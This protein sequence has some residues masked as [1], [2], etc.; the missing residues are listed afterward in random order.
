MV[1]AQ[2]YEISDVDFVYGFKDGVGGVHDSRTMMLAE[3]Q[4]LLEVC[5]QN[6]TPDQ[7]RTAVVEDNA[8]LKGSLEARRGAFRRLRELYGLNPE[9]LLF[10]ALRDLWNVESEVQPLIGLLCAVARDPVFRETADLIIE[11][12]PEQTVTSQMLA[13]AVSRAFQDRYSPGILAKIG[14]NAASS[15]TQSGHLLGRS[16]KVRSRVA[17]HPGSVAYALLLGYLCGERGEALFGTP[18]AQLLDAPVHELRQQAIL[19]GQMGWI[20]YRSGGGVTDIG[21]NYLLRNGKDG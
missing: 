5:P 19:A 12:P 18:W 7:Y 8:L 13:E 16:H 3:L 1:S 4:R 20:D 15:W 14:R 11:T 9:V 17:P 21:F 2:S 6:T 10:H